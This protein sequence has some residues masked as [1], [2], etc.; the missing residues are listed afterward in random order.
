[1]KNMLHKAFLC[2]F[3]ASS[4]C[5]FV[6]FF[7]YFYKVFNLDGFVLIYMY[8]NLYCENWDFIIPY[9]LYL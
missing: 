9:A 7:G 8:M 2:F 6:F 5:C 1:M 3:I 4:S